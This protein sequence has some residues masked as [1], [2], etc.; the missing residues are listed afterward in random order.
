MKTSK[1]MLIMGAL[2]ALFL[3]GGCASNPTSSTVPAGNAV[4]IADGPYCTGDDAC[5][6][7]PYCGGNDCT[8][9]TEI[10]KYTEDTNDYSATLPDYPE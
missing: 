5:D 8:A 1:L 2:T 7:N 4:D 6:Q 10:P 3:L 9:N